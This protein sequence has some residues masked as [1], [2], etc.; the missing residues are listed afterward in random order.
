MLNIPAT[1]SIF[2]H[3]RPTDMRKGF[4]GLSGYDTSVAAEVITGKYGYHLPIYRQQ[5]CFAGSGWTPARSTL[6]WKTSAAS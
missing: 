2:L 3:T 5:D 4:D 6:F 1:V